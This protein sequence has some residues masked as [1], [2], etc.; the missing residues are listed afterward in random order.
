MPVDITIVFVGG[1]RGDHTGARD[2]K[3]RAKHVGAWGV[4]PSAPSGAKGALRV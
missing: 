2:E 3:E 1:R 4:L